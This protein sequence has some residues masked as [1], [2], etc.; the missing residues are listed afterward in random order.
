[1]KKCP[2]CAEEIQDEAIVCKY[3]KRD[4]KPIPSSQGA[5]YPP[6]ITPPVAPVNEK[7]N[8]VIQRYIQKGYKI[9]SSSPDR[10]I[11]DRPAD[12][13]NSCTFFWLF[14]VFGIGALIYALIFWIWANHKAY[15]VQLILGPDGQVQEIG[16]TMH[17]FELDKIKA[18]RNKNLGFGVFFCVLG[19][20]VLISSFILMLAPLLPTYT[21]DISFGQNFLYSFVSLI[22]FSSVTTL[23]GILLML[24]ARKLKKQMEVDASYTPAQTVQA[25]PQ[26][27]LSYGAEPQ[28]V[29]PSPSPVQEEIPVVE[30]PKSVE[31][32]IAE[33][34]SIGRT[35]SYLP[36]EEGR[37]R[38][39]GA[40]LD[41]I[42]S[43]PLMQ[44]AH[45]QV[46]AALGY[47]RARELESAWAGIGQWLG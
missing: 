40:E 9:T 20:I 17:Q 28:T 39:I 37:T 42:G 13:F 15:N 6:S 3:C 12:Q 43:L 11:M 16:N 45:E 1:M 4:L 22:L 5:A 8:L 29:I 31:E 32:L 47:A 35:K 25:F 27:D 36:R 26:N 46:N 18:K 10:V 41:R 38:D 30:K 21:S 19:G 14:F 44:K 23:P 2:Y 34:I 7:L 33:L 24:K